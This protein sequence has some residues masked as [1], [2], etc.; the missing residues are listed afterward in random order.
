LEAI[1]LSPR[2]S[3]IFDISIFSPLKSV[4]RKLRPFFR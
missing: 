2:I 4:S 1:R 3:V